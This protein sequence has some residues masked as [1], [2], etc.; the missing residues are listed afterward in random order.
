GVAPL[1]PEDVVCCF[2]ALEIQLAAHVAGFGERRPG[3]VAA[4][5]ALHDPPRHCGGG[6]DDRTV[7][8][9]HGAAILIR[10]V[11]CATRVSASF[12]LESGWRH[13]VA[14]SLVALRTR[15]SGQESQPDQKPA[16]RVTL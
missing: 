14:P 16:R 12:T 10:H 1:S 9:S 4:R 8:D 7:D 13:G 15:K 5:E 6:S 11:P 3:D 2:L